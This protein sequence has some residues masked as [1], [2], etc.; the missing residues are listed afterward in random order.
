[1]VIAADPRFQRQLSFQ[2]C[3]RSIRPAFLNHAQQHV[4]DQK[5]RDQCSLD[6]LSKGE[7]HDDGRLEHP[8]NWGPEMLRNSSKKRIPSLL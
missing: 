2:K 7:L 8:R 3:K 4:E 1:M 6:A 5:G